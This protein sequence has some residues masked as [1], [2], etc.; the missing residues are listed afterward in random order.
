VRN[1]SAPTS[2]RMRSGYSLVYQ[3]LTRG[4]QASAYAI[5]ESTA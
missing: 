2:G 3:T 1:R 5:G 4:S